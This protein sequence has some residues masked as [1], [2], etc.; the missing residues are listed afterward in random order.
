VDILPPLD[1]HPCRWRPL[2]EKPI[3]GQLVARLG[4]QSNELPMASCGLI[5]LMKQMKKKKDKEIGMEDVIFV[6][7]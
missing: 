5:S 3:I 1:Y 4:Y 2:A 7:P 6:S